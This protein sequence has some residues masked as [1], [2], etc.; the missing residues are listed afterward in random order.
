MSALE[1]F[2]SKL[3][4]E[5]GFRAHGFT[6]RT[7]GVSEG[8]FKSLNLSFDVGDDPSNVVENLSRLKGAVS[9]DEFLVRVKQ[10]HKSKVVDAL[11][12]I[13]PPPGESS[14][15]EPP[16][17]EADG[18]VTSCPEMI[19]AVQTADCAPI[20]LASPGAKAVAAIHAGWK[21]MALGVVRNGVK[22]MVEMGA[23]PAEM[24]A[25]IGPCI[26][27]KCYE[28]GDEVAKNFPE[29]CDPIKKKPGKHLL[30]LGLA[31]EVSLIGAGLRGENIE[32]IETCTY[33][34]ESE[35]FSHR[36]DKGVTGRSLGFI[37]AK[38]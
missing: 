24:I 30:D 1:F 29:S 9:Q 20:L 31:A 7:G 3:L 8:P 13:K 5:S 2:R 18:M 38:K 12:A 36:R 35:L 37:S 19:L 6:K 25:V 23:G 28:V 26:C 22:S 34:S 21:S 33:C 17:L 27:F 16:F 32:R 11:S 4:E 10:V 15:S 14:W